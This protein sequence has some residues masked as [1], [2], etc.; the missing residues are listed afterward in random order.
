MQQHD[1]AVEPQV[2]DEETDGLHPDLELNHGST[3]EADEPNPPT[4][5]HELA[6]DPGLR[7]HHRR[8][9]E[10]LLVESHLR[11]QQW[12]RHPQARLRQAEPTDRRTV[13]RSAVSK[14]DVPSN[15]AWVAFNLRMLQLSVAN[16]T[17]RTAAPRPYLARATGFGSPLFSF[18][19]SRLKKLDSCCFRVAKAETV[20]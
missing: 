16:P 6:A 10:M 8:L 19:T 12:L 3:V 5:D 7:L 4:H 9:Q 1:L 2:R 15:D 17:R 20:S 18:P 14:S 13:D 11:R